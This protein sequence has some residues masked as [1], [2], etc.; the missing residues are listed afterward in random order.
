MTR[1][2]RYST[3]KKKEA[4]NE[5][6]TGYQRRRIRLRMGRIDDSVV[7]HFS[8]RRRDLRCLCEDG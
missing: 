8:D 4:A 3:A 5:G 7:L 6:R 2:Y 1:K